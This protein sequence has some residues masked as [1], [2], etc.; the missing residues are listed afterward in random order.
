MRIKF[1]NDSEWDD[2]DSIDEWLSDNLDPC[3]D[4]AYF[5]IE[6]DENT[7]QGFQVLTNTWA[8]VGSA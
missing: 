2:A 7:Y 1:V 3:M 6:G 8:L 4:G 5:H